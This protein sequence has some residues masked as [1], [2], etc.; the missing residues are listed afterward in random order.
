QARRLALLERAR[1]ERFAI[2]EDDYDHEFHY[3]GRPVAPL[4]S[5]DRHGSVI[6]MGSLSKIL[7]PGLRLGFV[8]APESVIATLAA[9]RGAIA[10]QRDHVPELAVAELVDDG[11]IQRHAHKLRR[12][13]AARREAFAAVL[14]R[15]LGGV[16]DVELPPGGI[17]L[18]AR[19]AP[20]VALEKW[21]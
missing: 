14:R 2:L 7:A 8:A 20:D 9:I 3:D 5:A 13:Y 17:T 4:A 18:W 11:E 21:R 16:L 19:V 15:E 1:R 10:R 12:T 6:Y